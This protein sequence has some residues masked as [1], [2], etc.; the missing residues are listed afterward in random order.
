MNHFDYKKPTSRKRAP[1]RRERNNT[2]RTGSEV[3]PGPRRVAS[4]W[5]TTGRIGSLLLLI[6]S[7]GGLMYV[8]TAPRFT[9]QDVQI[10]GA[11]IVDTTEVARLA[12]AQHQSIWFIDTQK[13]VKR[14]KTNAY[15][16]QVRAYV[17]LPD[18]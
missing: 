2:P 13:I 3:K 5:L 4:S 14:L 7:V 9:V 8:F 16:D 6:A 12:D 18:R 10:E 17:T 11:Q 1:A 15:I